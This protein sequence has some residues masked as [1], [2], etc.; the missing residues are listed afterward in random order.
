M[1]KIFL[2]K[3]NPDQPNSQDNWIIM[4]GAEFISF[5]RTPDGNRRKDMFARLEPMDSDECIYYAECDPKTKAEWEAAS[6]RY[7]YLMSIIKKLAIEFYSLDFMKAGEN[8][9]SGEEMLVDERSITDANLIKVDEQRMLH[10][11]VSELQPNEQ[12]LIR[13]LFFSNEPVTDRE[14]AA[15]Y[16]ISPQLLLYR[17]RLILEK[18]RKK[19]KREYF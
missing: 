19:L 17:K 18:L 5:L 6:H 12:E 14:A 10:K 7:K 3:K 16:G 8:T 15:R 9:K 13:I 11:A 1:K 2:V 4:N